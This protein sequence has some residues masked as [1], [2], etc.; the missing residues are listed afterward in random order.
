LLTGPST[1]TDPEPGFEALLPE[2]VGRR[3]TRWWT[4][5]G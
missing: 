1:W 5:R 2:F 3:E 4:P